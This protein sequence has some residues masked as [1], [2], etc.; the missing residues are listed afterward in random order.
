MGMFDGSCSEDYTF[1]IKQFE[2]GQAN[3]KCVL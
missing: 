2:R 1:S 3:N